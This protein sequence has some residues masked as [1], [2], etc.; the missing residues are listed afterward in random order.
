ML[1]QVN[2][3]SLPSFMALSHAVVLFIVLLNLTARPVAS[4]WPLPRSMQ[5]GTTPLILSQNFRV[6]VNNSVF[7]EDLLDAIAQMEP[8]L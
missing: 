7:P 2:T 1:D 8:Y 5:T 6:S 3:A 4:L